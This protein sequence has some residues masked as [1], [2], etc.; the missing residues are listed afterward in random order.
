LAENLQKRMNHTVI[1]ENRPGAATAIGT[2]L[3]FKSAPDGHTLLMAAADLAVLPAVRESLPYKIEDLTYLSR[4]WVNTALIVTGPNSG[5]NTVQELIEKIK[6][7]PGKIKNGTNGVGA[8]NHLGSLKFGSA[9][10]AKVVNIPYNGQGPSSTDALAGT[11][12]MINGVSVPLADGLK[13]LAPSG[14]FRHSNFPDLPTLAELGYKDADWDAWWGLLA[15]PNLPKPI[16]DRIVEEVNAVLQDP[17]VVEHLR[18]TA[19]HVP[20]KNPLTGE[21]FRKKTLE[22]YATWQAIAKRENLS[23]K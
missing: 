23:I 17:A 13:V 11:I 5:I 18:K 4:F 7:D 1:V 3:V 19:R 10:G 20:E 21:A 12:E 8:L 15:P 16:A 6:A 9:I 22:E 14:S 2:D